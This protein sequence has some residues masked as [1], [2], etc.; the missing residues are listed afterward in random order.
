MQ[1]IFFLNRDTPQG[2]IMVRPQNQ[3][4]DVSWLSATG[5]A[6]KRL[7]PEGDCPLKFSNKQ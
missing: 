7:P 5:G 2:K 4:A 3:E 6:S 1:A